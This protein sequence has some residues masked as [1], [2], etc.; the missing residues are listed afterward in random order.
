MRR[1]PSLD[2]SLT[3]LTY[4]CMMLFMGLAAIN[5]Q[6]NLLFAVF[7]LMI[8]VLGVSGL[9]SRWVLRKLELHRVFPEH[10]V[11]G[12]PASISYVFENRKR[13]WPSLSVT[14]GELDGTE[15]FTMQP[16]AYLL[17]VAAGTRAIVPIQV[18]PK[19]RGVHH[20]ERYQLSTSFPFGFVRRAVGRSHRDSILIYPPRAQVD[21]RLLMTCLSAE[22]TGS[23]MRPR[24]GGVDEF[25]GVKEYRTGENPRWIYWRRSARTGELVSKEMT[26]VAPPR[27]VI[28][29][30]TYLSERSIEQHA[31]VERAIAMACSLAATALD[32]GLAVGLCAWSDGWVAIPP[33]RGKRH[34]REMMAVLARLTL[35]TV[36][37][38]T[39][40]IERA[41]H[42][43]RLDTTAILMTSTGLAQNLAD[44]AKG[45]FLMI[46]AHSD[47]A[48]AWFRFP[49][50]VEFEHCMPADQEPVRN[51]IAE[52]RS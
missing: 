49:P 44:A 14:V 40:L 15:A 23:R 43:I 46:P 5:S 47:Q 25:Y 37:D 10:L 28:L 50:G 24:R 33:S 7:G 41:R 45:T 9:I 30:D 16:Q 8:G 32:Q 38:H 17:H 34:A 4:T 2:F 52:S 26:R 42:L 35:N 13:Y 22:T 18:M 31:G 27:L 51:G 36:Q 21:Q 6:A 39:S 19:R 48:H 11:V 20:F 29:V 1:R 3:G 12:Q